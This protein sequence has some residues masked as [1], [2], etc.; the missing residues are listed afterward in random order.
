MYILTIAALRPS[1]VWTHSKSTFPPKYWLC[2]LVSFRVLSLLIITVATLD[3]VMF[4]WKF[5]VVFVD[6]GL[7]GYYFPWH[8]LQIVLSMVSAADIS[9]QFFQLPL[10]FWGFFFLFLCFFLT[11]PSMGL[12]C[13]CVAQGFG[14]SLYLTLRSYLQ[15]ICSCDFPL[16]FP[17]A[18]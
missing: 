3:S 6:G 4:L 10:L 5:A 15:L 7:K 1:S 14:K 18:L 16:R 17:N 11:C 12:L 8:K 13:T 9:A 2:L